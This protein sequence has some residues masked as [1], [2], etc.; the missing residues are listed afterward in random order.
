[1]VN[2][3]AAW[4]HAHG[5]PVEIVAPNDASGGDEVGLR[6]T[7]SPLDDTPEILG[8][9]YRMRRSSPWLVHVFD[10]EAAAAARVGGAPYVQSV[11]RV[12]RETALESDRLAGRQ[13]EEAL[14]AARRIVCANYSTASLLE[15][16]LGFAATVV[17]EGIDISKLGSVP[18]RRMRPMILCFAEAAVASELMTVVEA[19]V[20]LSESI[21]DLQL[22]VVGCPDISLHR[23]LLE[24]VP[25]DRRGRLLMFDSVDRRR[26]VSLMSRAFVTCVASSSETFHRG[27]VES[28]ALGIAL[29]CT[30]VGWA[31]EIVDE[32]AVAAGVG[33]RFRSGDAEDCATQL[34]RL[35]DRSSSAEVVEA[36]KRQAALYDWSYVG[37]RL[38]DVYHH[39]AR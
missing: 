7:G 14:G 28:L 33:L 31:A 37:P 5:W 21:D 10:V 23:R 24:K 13:L 8:L 2:E 18:V 9:G 17:P 1:M 16:S 30:Q 39:A 34:A 3:L 20:A 6:R 4:L 19:F 25:V 26:I 11:T 29:A 35:M 36:C 22:A 27:A 12:P 38:V 15:E 32:D